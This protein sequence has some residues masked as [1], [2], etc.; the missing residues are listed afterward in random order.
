MAWEIEREAKTRAS[1]IRSELGFNDEPVSDIFNL[2]ESLDILLVSKPLDRDSF[3]AFF[4]NYKDS[5]L[6]F[7]NSSQSLGRQHFSAAH[8]LYHYYYDREMTGAICNT[9]K[10]KM[11]NKESE[12]LAD[13][14]AVNFL[15][16]EESILKFMK[17]IGSKDITLSKV[18]KAQLY[19]KVSF[20]AMLVRLRVLGL[21]DNTEYENFKASRLS[22][23]FP[24]LGYSTDIIKPTNNIHIPQKYIELL[25]EN[26]EN[27]FISKESYKHYLEEVGKNPIEYEDIEEAEEYVEEP[28]FDY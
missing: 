8:E 18:I 1:E 3:S 16:P 17:R 23:V 5:F 12:K 19:F 4:L 15:M 26:Y 9:F 14:F 28:S 6:I 25:N 13:Y 7:I 11:Q 24:K 2:I 20:S 21:L 27:G 22:Y 10:F